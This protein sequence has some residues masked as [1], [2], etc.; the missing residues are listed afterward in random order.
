MAVSV[1]SGRSGHE[2][3][4]EDVW[5]GVFT[6][7]FGHLGDGR[8]FVFCS[9]RWVLV[10][11][12]YRT[13]VVGAVPHA[14]DVVAVGRRRLTGINLA[15]EHSII[16]AVRDAVSTARPVRLGRPGRR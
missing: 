10:V 8:S 7:G 15:D 16:A 1:D 2:V 11:G 6:S 14:E 4:V 12:L 9:G 13:G 5:P 3:V